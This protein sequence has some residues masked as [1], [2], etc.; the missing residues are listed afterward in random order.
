VS[1]NTALHRTADGAIVVGRR[2]RWTLARYEQFGELEI[3]VG[4]FMT[5]SKNVPSL[6]IEELEAIRDL[7]LENAAGLI[8]DAELLVRQQRF[9]RAFSLSVI[10]I[11]EASKL[12]IL[13][14]C[15]ET[16]ATG[17]RPAWSELLSR[18]RNHH[19][20]LMANLLNF[21]AL[22][23]SGSAG[24]IDL[25]DA[26][27]RVREMNGFKQDGFYVTI[28]VAGV[29]A[30]GQS[31]MFDADRTAMVLKLARVSFN[32]SDLMWRGFSAKQAG[33]TEFDQQTRYKIEG[34]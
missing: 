17:G 15:A 9:P 22:R 6:T 21:R 16:I 27:A 10:A 33:Q 20:K 28:D 32:T 7:V 3:V 13:L 5:Q 26:I 23:S 1:A 2:E 11:E 29:R 8:A 4:T 24:G 19:E 31:Q 34:V 30:P 18:L 14:E 12:L 25:E